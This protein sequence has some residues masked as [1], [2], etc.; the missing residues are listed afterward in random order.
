M[1][2]LSAENDVICYLYIDNPYSLCSAAGRVL[3]TA[4]WESL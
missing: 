4:D 3:E 1:L 2:E